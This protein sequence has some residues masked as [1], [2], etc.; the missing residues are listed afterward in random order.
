[1]TSATIASAIVS[2]AV[3][4]LGTNA[5]QLKIK[6]QLD[7]FPPMPLSRTTASGGVAAGSIS[8]MR[9]VTA[10]R[11]DRL[12]SIGADRNLPF[13]LHQDVIQAMREI[14]SVNSTVKNRWRLMHAVLN[15]AGAAMEGPLGTA[16]VADDD[17]FFRIAI[18]SILVDRIG[19]AEVIEAASLDEALERLSNQ[20]EIALALFDLAMPGMESPA[21]LAAV[22]EHFPNMRVVV[23]SSSQRRRDILMALEAGVHGYV[24]KTLGVEDLAK[25]LE[26]I[27]EGFVYVPA[28]LSQL[29]ST[30]VGADRPRADQPPVSADEEALAGLTPRQREVLELIVAGKSNKEIARALNL[31][32]GT[33]KV[34][35]A[36]LFRN[37]G[38]NNR[39]A[40]AAAGARLLSGRG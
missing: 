18:R 15:G 27:L 3:A 34:H 8:Y 7:L 21:S 36:A 14:A 28:S 13:T 32:E 38:V 12:R 1:L 11:A 2:P 4:H 29:P 10:S 22:R 9:E 40:A 17:E 30:R 39:A 24:P 25:A 37:L 19:V 31:G 33:V 20:P 26:L 6:A 23:V 35:L 5:R 16:L